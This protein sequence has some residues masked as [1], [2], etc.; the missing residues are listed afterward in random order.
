MTKFLINA[1]SLLILGFE[2][3]ALILFVWIRIQT[4]PVLR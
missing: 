3:S 4:V 2:I 1:A